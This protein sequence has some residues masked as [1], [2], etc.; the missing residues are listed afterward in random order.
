MYKSEDVM[1]L[2]SKIF[3][4]RKQNQVLLNLGRLLNGLNGLLLRSVVISTYFF[5]FEELIETYFGYLG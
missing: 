4:L 5:R 2:C 3:L 1:G